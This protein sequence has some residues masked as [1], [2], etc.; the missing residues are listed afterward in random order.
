MRKILPLPR[1]IITGFPATSTTL[2]ILQQHKE[3]LPWIFNN[4]IQI[5][6][7]SPET[8]V[9][10]F[11]INIDNCPF[12]ITNILEKKFIQKCESIL[13]FVIHALEYGY[14]VTFMINTDK[15]SAYKTNMGCHDPLFYG[16]DDNKKELYFAEYINNSAYGKSFCTFSEFNDSI[17]LP[18]LNFVDQDFLMEFETI[19]L[20]KYNDSWF[21][22]KIQLDDERRKRF[23]FLPQLIKQSFEDYIYGRITTNWFTRI[24]YLNDK[25]KSCH[26]FGINCYDVLRLQLNTNW[27][28]G[29]MPAGMRQSYYVMYSHKL[30]QQYRI[31]YMWENGYLGNRKN[32]LE[33]WDILTKRM[34]Q[35]LLCVLK[36]NYKGE[37]QTSRKRELLMYIDQIEEQERSII[38][39]FLEDILI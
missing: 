29:M 4:Y 14:Y 18:E 22:Y 25:E 12:L 1:P 38:I 34:H 31:Q 20:I 9:D 35:I 7:A 24:P 2:S 3:T 17:H 27:E 10:F 26:Y 36:E 30:M 6:S 39:E 15:V 11:D 13:N 19:K 28:N 16:Y 37:F 8:N 5:F 21:Q 33:I 23:D 32:Y